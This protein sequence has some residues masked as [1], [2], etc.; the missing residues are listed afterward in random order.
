MNIQ[1]APPFTSAVRDLAH[2]VLQIVYSALKLEWTLLTRFTAGV[3]LATAATTLY[4]MWV[5]RNS[6]RPL[7]VW[8]ALNKPVIYL[9]RGW[10]FG[11]LLRQ[12]NP[13]C[14]TI[15]L[16]ITTLS[17]GTCSGF[18][19]DQHR[20][21]NPFKSI[22]ATA[23]CTFAETVGGLAALSTLGKKDRAILV[24]LNIEYKKKARGLITATAQFDLGK[25]SG[26]R[27]IDEEVILMDS[28]LDVLA[29]AKLTW[30]IETKDD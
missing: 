14:G 20:V 7:Q 8:E 28:N 5:L 27:D 19:T 12:A 16:R 9:L 15:N 18:M 13:Y 21:R 22:H 1:A 25:E 4:L 30:A 23:L 24:A 11:L 17:K 10:I 2:A 6:R 3:V 26:K 29:V